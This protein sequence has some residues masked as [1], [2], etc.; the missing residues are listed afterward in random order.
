VSAVFYSNKQLLAALN[1][2]VL[3]I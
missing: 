1:M 3:H 2:A